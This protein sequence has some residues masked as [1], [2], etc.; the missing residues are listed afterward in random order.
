MPLP[1]RSTPAPG[2]RHGSR[3]ASSSTRGIGVVAEHRGELHGAVESEP[4]HHLRAHVVPFRVACLPHARVRLLPADHRPVRE[5]HEEL[6]GRSGQ[7]AE[8]IAKQV[9]GVEH[10]TQDVELLLVPRRVPDPHGRA[11]AVTRHVLEHMLAQVTLTL[12]AVHDLDQL[13]ADVAGASGEPVEQPSRFV[14]ARCDPQRP[15]GETEIT[16]PGEA[17]V[18]V[19][20][21]TQLFGQRRGDGGHDGAGRS[22]RQPLQHQRA[23]A[24]LILEGALVGGVQRRPRF[25]RSPR[26]VD[27]R[28]LAGSRWSRT[29]GPLVGKPQ[30]DC[31]A[32]GDRERGPG[33]AV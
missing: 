25:P 1:D 14:G 11:A 21:A 15:N 20:L 3:R 6:P 5:S 7:L 10:L 30:L 23:A 9:R 33:A 12:H 13:V 31:L 26:V 24:H 17:V 2:R 8:L 29:V 22:V 19:E 32:F 27:A 4:A 28:L 18:E 16:Q